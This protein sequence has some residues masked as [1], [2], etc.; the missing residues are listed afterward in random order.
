MDRKNRKIKSL[1]EIEK[2]ARRA[3]AR[4]QKIVTTNGAFDLLHV[5]HI[6]SLEKA[7]ALGDVLIVGVNSD[8]SV[9]THKDPSRPIVPERE[10]A[11]MVAS[12]KPVDHVFIFST[13]TPIPWIKKI[14]PHVHAKGADRTM[15][16][17]VER[18]AVEENGGKIVLVPYLKRHSTTG[19][20]EK[21]KKIVERRPRR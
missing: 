11:A 1:R 15:D 6:D 3:R 17:I 4:G 20:I 16:Q 9:R 8:K 5:G 2:I 18:F 19:L 14:K 21:V 12:L 13:P 10:R 7:K